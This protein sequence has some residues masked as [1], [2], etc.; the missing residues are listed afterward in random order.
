MTPLSFADT[1]LPSGSSQIQAGLSLHIENR[2]QEAEVIYR[3]VLSENP[4]NVDALCLLGVIAEQR[5]QGEVALQLLRQ[6]HALQVDHPAVVRTLANTLREF[7]QYAESAQLYEKAVLLEPANLF[8]WFSYASVLQQLGRHL[9]ALACYGE[10]LKINNEHAATH[11]DMG[12]ALIVLERYA[13]ATECLQ[14]ALRLKPDY[15]E[16]H[17]NLG[18]VCKF[19]NRLEEAL[20][21]YLSA[22]ELKPDYVLAMFNAGTIHFLRKQFDAAQQWYKETLAL[23]PD[24]YGARIN[25]A[26]IYMELEL[27]AQAKLHWDYIYQRQPI[28][29]ERAKDPIKTVVI[30]LAA[31]NGNVPFDHLFPKDCFDRISC[32]M[33]YV[34]DAQMRALPP[35]DLVFNAI[36]DS[37]A[38]GPTN[39]AV[40]GFRAFTEKPFLNSPEAVASTS[41]EQIE[42]LFS[43]IPKV[44][45]A[46]TIRCTSATLKDTV[47]HG[48]MLQFPIVV[49]PEKSHGGAN[50][51]KLQSAEG[52]QN[53]EL[54]ES[55]V[56][57]ASNFMDYVSSDGYYRK[58]RMVFINRR[59]FP[60]HL[61][62][63]TNWIVHYFTAD[64]L[65]S[66]WKH[67]E[68]L[69][70]LDSPSTVLGEDAMIAIEAIGR[71]MDLD[72][73][74]IDFAQLADGRILV[75]EANATMLI[76]GEA[77][78][79]ALA[80]KNPYVQR[81][82]EA[83]NQ[84]YLA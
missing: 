68:E 22:I 13:E 30:L 16:A 29:I 48:N 1:S 47:L 63:S 81:I 43:G 41:R 45:C 50:F 24:H 44:V 37:D 77:P 83:F 38:C 61:A 82:F 55:L 75:F 57:Y 79:G 34:S 36:G 4:H 74:G 64:M 31:G 67:Q 23:E 72:Y 18:N 59:P 7:G 15:A 65:G 26:S 56:Y 78:D 73:C 69:A 71:C 46:P 35:Y 28:T 19:E 11:N 58:Y 14:Q 6:A 10:I 53:L 8:S 21:H 70:Y 51:V 84:C 60:Y 32:M 62:I 5:G 12:V 2:L 66:K 49:R 80:Y 39:A 3:E 76:H 17:L 52:L 27:H 33:E 54:F 9:D 42:K 25:M 40:L 20:T